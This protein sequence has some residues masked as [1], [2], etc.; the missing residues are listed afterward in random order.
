MRD[1]V[2][3]WDYS[4]VIS[5]CL[6]TT[7]QSWGKL[8]GFFTVVPWR[9]RTRSGR[10][11]PGLWWQRRRR[12]DGPWEEGF[13]EVG[14]DHPVQRSSPRRRV[15]VGGSTRLA[16]LPENRSLP[17]PKASVPEEQSAE[18]ARA[19]AARSP[20]DKQAAGAVERG[21]AAGND[22]MDVRM[23]PKVWAQVWRTMV[24]RAW[25]QDAWDRA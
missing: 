17:A 5:R 22:A 2:A 11:F 24:M 16:S 20:G 21:A 12:S 4:L 13:D 19:P 1:C 9:R 18:Q 3:S 7:G 10:A 15:K 25:R 6:G 8:L 23:I 14:E